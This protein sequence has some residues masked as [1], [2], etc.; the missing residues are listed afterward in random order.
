MTVPPPPI[1]PIVTIQPLTAVGVPSDSD[2][3]NVLAGAKHG[4]IIRGFVVNR[5]SNQNPILRTPLGDILVKSDI[6]L[7]TGSDVQIRV[8]VQLASRARIMMIDGHTPEAYVKLTQ[9]HAPRTDMILQSSILAQARVATAQPANTSGTADAELPTV[10]AVILRQENATAPIKELLNLPIGTQAKSPQPQAQQATLI[11]A[12]TARIPVGSQVQVTIISGALPSAVPASGEAIAQLL[13]PSLQNTVPAQQVA[14]APTAQLPPQAGATI[15]PQQP[16][17]APQTTLPQQ[18]ASLPPAATPQSVQ[19][20]PLSQ[21]TPATTMPV[22][23]PS[24]QALVTLNT[25]PS[26]PT[27]PAQGTPALPAAATV[28]LSTHD[29]EALMF[30]AAS[31]QQRVQNLPP[32]LNNPALAAQTLGQDEA[33]HTHTPQNLPSSYRPFAGAHVIQQAGNPGGQA[34]PQTAW[35]G[36]AHIPQS[37]APTAAAAPLSAPLTMQP[38]QATA[39]RG[40]IMQVIGHE[41]DGGTIVKGEH[42]TL[43]LFTAKPLPTGTSLTVA[44][45]HPNMPRPIDGAIPAR[46]VEFSNLASHWP[47][48]DE[49]LTA[50]SQPLV[51]GQ[52]P[53][54]PTTLIPTIGPRLT[55]DLMLFLSVVRGGDFT[56]LWPTQVIKQL[57]E[58]KPELLQRLQVDMGN[59]QQLAQPAQPQ[60]QWSVYLVPMFFG[61]EAQHM[62]LFVRSDDHDKHKDDAIH[63]QRFIMEIA[64]SNLGDMQLDG[65]VQGGKRPSQFDLVIRTAKSLPDAVEADISRLFANAIESTR[66]K[67]RIIF[68]TGRE[69]FIS[70][71]TQISAVNTAHDGDFT[72]LA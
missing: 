41:P 54:P 7:K 65:F 51:A 69:H 19:Q 42:T 24:G 16:V 45:T 64:L 11:A 50:L 15:T 61:Q 32:A 60:Q 47:A 4:D 6:F 9:A 66:L 67:G 28:N 55:H 39:P 72:L 62:R 8:D 17:I 59:M 1:N 58:L 37:P 44:I 52:Q 43:K 53:I 3:S 5:D 71:A 25:A 33:P 22:T 49:A 2:A 36:A 23:T 48:L 12:A 29:V 30:T 40:E 13:T 56:K 26:A 46:L 38:P 57:E 35:M 63:N 18:P 31:P 68:Q 21:I 27:N 70:P 20:Q 14:P 10:P 34:T